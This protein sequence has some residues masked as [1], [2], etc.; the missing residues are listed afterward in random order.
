MSRNIPQAP[1]SREVW[2]VVCKRPMALRSSWAAVLL[3]LAAAGGCDR[4]VAGG[5]ADGAAVYK[6]VCARCHGP[7]GVPD[8]SMVAR[9]GVKPLVSDHV[10]VELGD[11]ELRQQILKGSAN[12]QMPAFAGALTDAQID[13]VVEYVRYLGQR[14]S[15]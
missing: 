11:A 10:K 13:A 4:K 12:R 9:L 15:K 3:L 8:T 6:E 1:T 2:T 7:A 5:R 14:Q